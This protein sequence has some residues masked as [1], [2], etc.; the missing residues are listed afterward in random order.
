MAIAR[1]LPVPGDELQTIRDGLDRQ[2][3]A[4]VWEGEG[5]R[6]LIIRVPRDEP[7]P[8]NDVEEAVEYVRPELLVDI[9][10]CLLV[11][12]KAA[13]VYV[14]PMQ[15][16]M[17]ER[18]ALD[19]RICEAMRAQLPQGLSHMTFQSPE[20]PR[21]RWRLAVR[22]PVPRIAEMSE[23]HL[24]DLAEGIGPQLATPRFKQLA[25]VYLITGQDH[26]RL[27]PAIF[28]PEM[29]E[30]WEDEER[31]QRAHLAIAAKLQEEKQQRDAERQRL[32][33][34]MESRLERVPSTPAEPVREVE[35]LFE[36]ES[37]FIT[38]S[39]PW[40]TKAE[41]IIEMGDSAATSPAAPSPATRPT[42]PA[43]VGDAPSMATIEGEA[44]RHIERRNDINHRLETLRA[45]VDQAIGVAPA[46]PKTRSGRIRRPIDPDFLADAPAK[47]AG[48]VAEPEAPRKVDARKDPKGALRQ[49]LISAGFEVLETPDIPGHIIDLA[50]ER[51]RGDPQRVVA[52]FAERLDPTTAKELLKTARELEVDMVLCVTE[53]PEPEGQRLLVATKVKAMRPADVGRLAV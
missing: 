18:I 13:Q 7:D 29:Q 33:Q 16:L 45:R 35:P 4:D 44:Q 53:H 48:F 26:V 10:H 47:D 40:T 39:G 42:A 27:E 28:L 30:K 14:R 38:P 37:T 12:A 2:Y 23:H 34:E 20:D 43:P 9:T 3:G 11:G 21:R 50:A 17:A 8:V 25:A 32:M 24:E 6:V 5:R 36:A 1:A 31:R 19:A 52:R 41:D 46:T 15:D 22:I 49:R 51:P